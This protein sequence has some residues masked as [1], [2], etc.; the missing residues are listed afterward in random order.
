M[1]TETREYVVSFAPKVKQPKDV[2]FNLAAKHIVKGKR[3]TN[4][5]LSQ[6][7]DKIVYGK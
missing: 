1:T 6:N 5:R 7:I 4:R 2:F 3:K